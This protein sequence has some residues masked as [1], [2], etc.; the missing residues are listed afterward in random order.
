V[1]GS[2]PWRCRECRPAAQ[3]LGRL[4][5]GRRPPRRRRGPA[6]FSTTTAS[7]RIPALS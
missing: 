6:G 5:A 7:S 2:C 1:Q 4:P 3:G